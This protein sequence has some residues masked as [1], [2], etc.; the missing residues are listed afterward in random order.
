M[1]PFEIRLDLLKMAQ[2]Y[3][4]DTYEMQ[5]KYV[6]DSASRALAAGKITFDEFQKYIPEKIDVKDIIA[7]ANELNDFIKTPK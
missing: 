2:K 5:T 3:L 7:K 6:L 4:T 1:T